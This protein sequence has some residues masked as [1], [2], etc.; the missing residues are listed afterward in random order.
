M[1]HTYFSLWFRLRALIYVATFRTIKPGY[2]G[3]NSGFKVRFFS[4]TARDAL[5]G[6]SG[7]SIPI[8]TAAAG[9]DM[10]LP[11]QPA[12]LLPT[13]R[14]ARTPLDSPQ[15][16]APQGGSLVFPYGVLSSRGA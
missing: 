3:L 16:Q 1:I 8:R 5:T 4:D 13:H 10:C 6:S 11:F 14:R 12:K 7:K 2:E 15:T 9:E